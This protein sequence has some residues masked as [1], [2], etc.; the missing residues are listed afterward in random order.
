[1]SRIDPFQRQSRELLILRHG[2]SDWD[3]GA[4]N[5]F[6]RPLAKRGKRDAPRVGEWLYREGLVPTYVVSSPAE[7]ARQTAHKV[8]KNLDHK[9]KD[10]VWDSDIYD[11]DV[12]ALI[13]V[14]GRVPASA[15]L[16][17]LVGHNPGLEDL[18]GYLAG[19]DFDAPDDGKLL[20]TAATARLEMPDD[21]SQLD[22]GCAVLLSITKPKELA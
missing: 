20:T 16:V 19:G 7:R 12:D 8:C 1:M 11:A 18:I 13:R 9:Y 17:L 14:L 6:K 15:P 10:V 4:K 2:K 22:R 21:W 5:D 3:S